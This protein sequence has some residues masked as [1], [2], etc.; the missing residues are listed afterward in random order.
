MIFGACSIAWTESAI[1]FLN[2]EH[3]RQQGWRSERLEAPAARITVTPQRGAEAGVGTGAYCVRTCDGYYFPL[4]SERRSLS[5]AQALCK[6]LCPAAAT[7]VYSRR[8][9]IEN[10]VSPKGKRYSQIA[11]AFA[12]RDA[13]DAR[14]QLPERDRPADERDRGSDLAPRRHRG[15]VRGRSD[16]PGRPHGP[17]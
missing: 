4:S 7:E 6:A 16:I 8:D 14:L 2:N 12:Y 1:E 13:I 11:K 17:A 5:E 3:R 9:A 10:A 15:H